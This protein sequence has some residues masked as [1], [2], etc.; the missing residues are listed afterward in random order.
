MYVDEHPRA[1]DPDRALRA[2]RAAITVQRICLWSGPVFLVVFFAGI[3]VCGWMPPLS[4]NHTAAEIAR[5]Y[6]DDYGQIRA[7][8]LLIG[9]SGLFQGVWSAVLS[10]QLRRIENHRPLLTY[11]Q[12]V[13]GGVGILVVVLPAFAFAAAAYDPGRDPEITKAINDF[14]WLCLVGVG[15]PTILQ[16]LAVAGAVFTDGGVRPVF[17]RWFG[18]AN[19]WVSL[20][21]LPGPFLIFFHTGAFAWNGIAVFWVPGSV[22][23]AWFIVCFVLLRRAIDGEEQEL[24][25]ALRVPTAAP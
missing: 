24:G 15:W 2:A 12:L 10:V 8:A 25:Q 5:M 9:F 4:A 3:I 1:T 19:L 20:G 7:G 11:M 6:R 16:C 13:A 14:G 22:F 18:W 17:P 21:L 23:G